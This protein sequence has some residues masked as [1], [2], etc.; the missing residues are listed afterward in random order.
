[1]SDD[2]PYR[3]GFQRRAV[4]A[5]LCDGLTVELD[6]NGEIH[7]YGSENGAITTLQPELDPYRIST[8]TGV[9]GAAFAFKA[10]LR[11]DWAEVDFDDEPYQED[12][13]E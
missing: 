2:K 9:E 12:T 1:M 7:V 13:D 8:I 4:E 10:V 11:A 3:N 5:L 6:I